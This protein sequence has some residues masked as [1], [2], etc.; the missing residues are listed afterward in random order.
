MADSVRSIIDK[1]S[2]SPEWRSLGKRAT[3]RWLLIGP[4]AIAIVLALAVLAGIFALERQYAGRIYPGVNVLRWDVGGM[5]QEEADAYLY[6][7]IRYYEDARLVFRSGGVTWEA[8]PEQLGAQL[9]TRSAVAEAYA[10][11]RGSD[12]R[13]NLWRQIDIRRHGHTVIP[14]TVFDPVQARKYVEGLAE[15]INFPA[16]NPDVTLAGFT[17]EVTPGRLGR[18]LDVEA[19]LSDIQQRI[20]NHSETP[21]ELQVDIIEPAIDDAPA[22]AA[23]ERVDKLLSAPIAVRYQDRS[24]TISREMLRQWL[25]FDKST[26]NGQL[27]VDVY[28]DPAKVRSWVEPLAADVYQL[29]EDARLDFNPDTGQVQVVKT[30]QEGRRLNVDDTVERILAATEGAERTVA[31]SVVIEKPAVDANDVGNMGIRELVVSATTYFRGSPAGRVNNIQVSASQFQGVVVP[32]GG[33]FSF[34]RYLGEVTE[35]EGYEEAYIIKGDRTAVGIGG[36]VCQVSTTV[37]RAA[38]FGGFPIEERWAHGYRVGWYETNSVPGLDATIFSP[39]V[40]FK[41]RNDTGAY[42]LVETEVDARAGT[43]TFYFY[44][45][46]PDRQVELEGPEITG[47]TPPSDP[48]YEVSE[49]LPPGT[50]KQIDWANEGSDVTL[51][52][53]I[54]RDGEVVQ[55][56]KFDSHYQAWSDVYLVSP[57]VEI[58]EE[59][60]GSP[61]EQS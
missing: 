22:L 34:N 12:L 38:F 41:F 55:R 46:K 44:G 51:Y 28:V 9:D 23:K 43:V 4:S 42:L 11:G 50:I 54:K 58:P 19:V 10:V 39:L 30:S 8:S 7:K 33:V 13:T 32:P 49:E 2:S 5:T 26:A 40:D 45:T 47:V 35:E 29:P 3:A 16:R 37:F 56:E 53:I 14:H 52:R 60:E 21:I 36:G 17:A 25:V 1:R 20:L 31:L 59:A 18:R 15:K 27:S 6:D 24:W 61:G 57:D 48:V